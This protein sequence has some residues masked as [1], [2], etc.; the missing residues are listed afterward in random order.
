MVRQET[1]IRIRATIP[2]VGIQKVFILSNL[3]DLY[4]LC[5]HHILCL[6]MDIM[7]SFGK[8]ERTLR[9]N[10]SNFLT[11]CCFSRFVG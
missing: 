2:V 5:N 3:C 6:N 8:I 9:L 4:C 10:T 1:T 7:Q 11:R